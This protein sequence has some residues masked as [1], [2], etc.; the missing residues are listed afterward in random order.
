MTPTSFATT[1]NKR[2]MDAD[3][4]GFLLCP[5]ARGMLAYCQALLQGQADLP[6]RQEIMDVL[7]PPWQDWQELVAD[8]HLEC[9]E[10][11]RNRQWT[12]DTV[13]T[14]A[15]TALHERLFPDKPP[16]LP[17]AFLHD[18]TA[19]ILG[20]PRP[21]RDPGTVAV[22]FP[23]VREGGESTL[24]QFV[25]ELLDGD[26]QVF[27]HPRQAFL[28]LDPSFRNIF[29]HAPDAL[30]QHV[31][32]APTGDVR[33]RIEVFRPA[34]KAWD[35]PL[36]GDSAGGALALG[37]WSLWTRTPLQAGVIPSFALAVPGKEPDGKCHPI[38]GL[39]PKADEIASIFGAKG[40]FLV[41]AAQQ[42]DAA[43]T[44]RLGQYGL[45]P[46][47]AAT[48]QNAVTAASG[49]LGEVLAY[50]DALVAEANRVP[51]Y[52]PRDARLD[53]VRVRVRVSSERK[54]FD[55]AWAEEQERNRLL[56]MADDNPAYR[57]RHSPDAAP[58]DERAERK[59]EPRVEVLD[60]DTQVH[61][62]VRLGAVVGDPG[63]GKTWLVKWEAARYADEART[64]LRRTGDLAAVTLPIYRRL[65]DVAAALHT[66]EQRRDH[67]TADLPTLPDAVLA[68]LQTWELPATDQGTSRRLSPDTLQFLRDRLGT[69]RVV[70][71]LDAFDEVHDEQRPSL[72][73]VLGEW[74]PKNPA[75]WV[76]FTSRVVGYQQ[77]WTFPERS[78]T[79]REMELLPFDD[80]QMGTFADAFFAGEPA[81]AK[82]LRE[83][84]RRTPQVRGMAQ[85]PLLLGFLCALYREDRQSRERRDWNLMRRTDLYEAVLQRLLNGQWKEPPRRLT[86]VEV[87]AKR[88]MLE[89]VAYHLFVSGKEQFKL[90]DVRT[91]FR[92]AHAALYPGEPLTEKAVSRRIEEWSE[93]DGVLVKAGAGDESPYLFLH[94]T[95]QEYL[96]ACSL[97]ERINKHGWDKATVPVGEKAVAA[98]LLVDRKAWLPQWQEVIILLA[99]KLDDPVPLLE[100]LSDDATDDVFRHRLALAALCLPEIK[101]LL[102]AP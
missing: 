98:K 60:W 9:V 26:G 33:V 32:C 59:D 90:R 46:A 79:E 15:L 5:M 44:A 29:R 24:V 75:A 45:Q 61:G 93:E 18:L 6:T 23:L 74:V 87:D 8:V 19:D 67:G 3:R 97:A 22:L 35:A 101:E 14:A 20:K 62:K 68:S 42:E 4:C 11:A 73:R 50:L 48:L 55:R 30:R 102:E 7:R 82:D 63:L 71:L 88:E 89:P 92:S 76:L 16:H 66:L 100:L 34:G 17:V 99:G 28:S 96:T 80:G 49:L 43:L 47:G 94:L 78:E 13:E 36:T 1:W 38:G 21:V 83:L 64:A 37:L 72:L 85:I 52:Y 81:A 70:L 65:T 10:L 77:P 2:G 84:L 40:V 51:A 91:A 31:G 56:G 69:E 41:A 54:R 95:F 27:L 58:G 39:L 53:R 25:L 57:H 12:S 86:E